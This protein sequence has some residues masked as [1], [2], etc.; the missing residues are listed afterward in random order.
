[1]R[2]WR[3]ERDSN[4]RS[5]NRKAVFK[6]AAFNHSAIPPAETLLYSGQAL[7]ASGPL[8]PKIKTENSR[9]IGREK[10]DGR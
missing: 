7:T 6:T 5:G 1:M 3:R 10:N 2:E 8:R 9:P 4:P